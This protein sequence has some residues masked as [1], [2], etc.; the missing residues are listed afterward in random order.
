MREV[1]TQ[2]CVCIIRRC[3]VLHPERIYGTGISRETRRGG[4][5]VSVESLLIRGD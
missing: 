2:K 1:R 5:V 3:P 4:M